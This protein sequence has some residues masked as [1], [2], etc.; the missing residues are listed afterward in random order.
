MMYLCSQALVRASYHVVKTGVIGIYKKTINHA[1]NNYKAER[2]NIMKKTFALLNI[3][4]VSL[5]VNAKVTGV[6]T[7]NADFG[8]LEGT[9]KAIRQGW[10]DVA[11]VGECYSVGGGFVAAMGNRSIGN[12]EN[13]GVKF[14]TMQN[15]NTLIFRVNPGYQITCLRMEGFGTYNRK[16]TDI[17]SCIVV[18][19]VEVD[20]NEMPFTGGNFPDVA[21]EMTSNLIIENITASDSIKLFFDNSNTE[22][23]QIAAYYE[24]DWIQP[25]SDSPTSTTISLSEMMISIGETKTLQA[26]FTGGSFTG[27]WVSDNEAVATV[28]SEGVVK[29]VSVGT[30]NISYQWANDNSKDAYKATCSVSVS[31]GFNPDNYTILKEYDFTTMGD[32]SLTIQEEP[33]GRIWNKSNN[34]NANVFPCTN[35]GLENLAVQSVH[36]EDGTTRGYVIRGGERMGLLAT[37]GRCAAITGIK[38]GQIIEFRH[39]SELDFFTKNAGEDDGVKKTPLVVE[40]DRH[41]FRALESGMVGF[42]LLRSRYVNSITI[43]QDNSKSFSVTVNDENG[44][45]ITNGVTIVWYDSDGKQIGTGHTIGGVFDDSEVYYSVLLDESLGYKYQELYQQK[46]DVSSESASCQLEP[47][48]RITIQGRVAVIDIDKSPATVSVKQMLN[49]KYEST[50]T[51][52]TNAHGEFSLEVYDYD[53][54]ITISRNDCF[55]S[56]LHRDRFN[57]NGNLGIIPMNLISG[58]SVSPNVTIQKAVATGEATSATPWIES[59]NNIEFELTNK[60]KGSAITDFTV[61]N[62]N[63]IIKEGAAE[64]DEIVLKAKSKQEL[65][66][67][68]VAIFR[69]TSGGSS[70]DLPL[71]ELGGIDATC[72]G[73][74]NI[75]T[76]GYLYDSNDKLIAKGNYTGETLSLRHIKNGVY[77]L[78]SMGKSLLLGSLAN[79]SDLHSV[80]LREGTDYVRANVTVLDGYLTAV[81]I[82]EV[83]RIDEKR[84]YYTNDNS[85]FSANKASVIVGNYLTLQAHLD[86]KPEYKEQVESVTLAIDL[87]EGCQLS[88]QSIIANRQ[89]VAHTINGNRVTITLSKDQYESQLKLCVIPT[90]RKNYDITAIATF[91]INGQVSQPVGTAHFE[92]KDI[93]ISVPSQTASK[94]ITVNGTAKAHSEVSVYDNDI[95]IGKNSSKADGTWT[96]Q[97]D[98]YRTGNHSF[99]DI[100]AKI[101]TKEGIELIS[102]T[103]HIEYIKNSIVP[104]KVTM[105]YYNPEFDINYNIVFDLIKG[106][107]RPSYYYYFPYKNW[108]NWWQTYETEPKDFTFLADFTENDTTQIYNVNIKVLNNDGTVRT[109]PA[110]YDQKQKCWVATTKYSSAFRIPQNATVEYDINLTYSDDDREEFF[111]D[112]ANALTSTGHYIKKFFDEKVEMTIVED[113]DDHVLLECRTEGNQ[114][115]SYYRI[116]HI[117][118]QEIEQMMKTHQFVYINTEEGIVGLYTE[119]LA[120]GVSVYVADFSSSSACK[121][122]LY[123]TA[124]K[125]RAKVSAEKFAPLV[126]ALKESVGSGRFLSETLDFIGNLA[127]LV[128]FISAIKEYWN[129]KGDFDNMCDIILHYSDN[130]L[131][132]NKKTFDCLLAK[133]PDGSYKL[134]PEKR[135]QYNKAIQATSDVEN[136]F[137]EQYFMYLEE[138][139]GKLGLSVITYLGTMGFGKAMK[140]IKDAK[141]FK[142]ANQEFNKFL[143]NH[144]TSIVTEET[145]GEILNSAIGATAGKLVDEGIGQLDKIFDYKDFNGVRDRT[146]EWASSEYTNLLQNYISIQKGIKEAYKKCDNEPDDEDNDKENDGSNDFKGNGASGISD[147][148]GYVYEAVMT[149]RIEGVTTTCYQQENGKAVVWNAEDYSQQN[150]L[151]TDATGFYRW[152]VPMGLWQVKYEKE[153]YETTY[154]DWLPVPPPQLDVN[155]GMKQSTPP[156]VKQMRGYEGGITIETAKYMRP[157]TMTT[158]N[159]TVTRNGTAEVGTIEMLNAEQAPLDG[160]T[161]VSKVKFVPEN[162]LNSTDLVVVTVH[163]EVESYCGVQMVAD[164]VET[165]KIESE[166]ESIVTDSVVTIPYQATRDLR[167]LVLPKDASAGRKLRVKTSSPMIASLS[168]ED[169]TIGKD[170]AATLTLGGELPG[171]A[172][173][174][175]SVEGTDVTATSRVKVVKGRELVAMPKANISSGETVDGGTQIVL[176]CDTKG[177]TIYYTLDGSCPCDEGTRYKYDGPFSIATD[178]IVKAIAVKGDMDDSDIATFVYVVNDINN[179]DNT[180][181][182]NASYNDGLLTI[183]GAE[184]SMCRVYDYRGYELAVCEKLSYKQTINIAK[185]EAYIVSVTF[186]DGRTIVQKVRW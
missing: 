45:P 7:N 19:K 1:Y 74:A 124:N 131:E 26:K 155:V 178:V 66:A 76:T 28:S 137:R 92:A 170:G 160:E 105:L 31:E 79:L 12:M 176:T 27:E 54:N 111:T 174:N 167:V 59:L 88:E 118:Y 107:T 62:G 168:A 42:E 60:T 94:T 51:V 150:P 17:E 20:G 116:D 163:K 151:K 38:K 23:P 61:Q 43:Y 24:L 6:I 46:A 172:V 83:P 89:T 104:K 29:G 34:R 175:L 165:V 120:T 110:S 102:E 63:I 127:D 91:D 164:H 95:L 173:L 130:L 49:G 158:E 171:G 5:Y 133:C 146:L 108:P 64:G 142:K 77:T 144:F 25:L 4:V 113:F 112:Q 72:S 3:L 123:S 100:Y 9:E 106:T 122:T 36:T 8:F 80:G 18:T 48:K 147:P 126:E 85:Y 179:V 2:Q 11:I 16:N 140:K 143:N 58:F 157:E 149:N 40:S 185:A 39:T 15:D 135:E 57:G 65:F 125:S 44:R 177:A 81:S 141:W 114:E 183:E 169:V 82:N 153:G 181:H 93:S 132:V 96:I 121:M 184:G 33:A 10:P 128:S 154:S 84:F 101:V 68:T 136:S 109:L 156:T 75:G 159:I 21:S 52:Q 162:R 47:I 138:Y 67:E 90:A 182:Y 148:S 99:H 14:R 73:S 119:E 115:P 69:I 97:C 50:N 13:A 71:T 145:S 152:D 117:D 98:L 22:G 56:S 53:A 166:V 35:A 129:V 32:V 186:S 55:D 87:P 180:H 161:Y 134:S 70:F 30:A 139:K 41:V 86:F 103:R 78:V 37:M